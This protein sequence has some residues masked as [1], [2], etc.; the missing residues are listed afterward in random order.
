MTIQTLKNLDVSGKTVLV[1]VDFNVPIRNGKI[2]DATRIEAHLPTIE[3]LMDRNAKV[4]LMSHLGR[5]EGQKSETFSLQ[6]IATRLSTLLGKKVPLA[7][8]C[9]GEKT[10]QTIKDL[11]SG[12]VLLLENLRFYREEEDNAP[13]FAKKLASLAEIY[14]NDAFATAHRSHASTVGVAEFANQTA[15][16]L[17][18]EKELQALDKLLENP[19]QPFISIIGGAKVSTKID[20]LRHLLPKSKMMMIGGAMANTFLASM[21]KNMGK[22]LYESDYLQ[23]A[24]RLLS[25]SAAMGCRLLLPI[26][27]VVASELSEHAKTQVVPTNAVPEGMLALDIGPDTTDLWSQMIA[28]AGTVIWNGP[29]GVAEVPPFHKGSV[30]IAQAVAK[31]QAYSVVGGGDTISALNKTEF[32]NQM[33]YISTG[34]GALIEALEGRALP[35]LAALE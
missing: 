6:P 17:L 8:D 20:V 35:G 27:L 5:P 23:A 22:S 30:A 33:S 11:P 3:W 14:V 24:H 1:R 28:K 25:D 15:M 10:I 9:I 4:V 26:D 32:A 12:G 7:P 13:A 18:M 16:G 29:M 34:G 31:S 2:I 19:T 21:G